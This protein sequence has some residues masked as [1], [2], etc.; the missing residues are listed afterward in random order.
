MNSWICS[1]QIRVL[2]IRVW[3]AASLSVTVAVTLVPA[4][5]KGSTAFVDR[6]KKRF[7]FLGY[8]MKIGRLFEA[9]GKKYRSF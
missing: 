8:F 3:A 5:A 2:H 6:L 7:K 9:V 4:R 1:W